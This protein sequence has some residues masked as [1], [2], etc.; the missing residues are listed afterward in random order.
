M[1]GPH[2]ETVV[3]VPPGRVGI[4]LEDFISDVSNTIIASVSGS[5]P[6]AGKVFQGDSIISVNGVDVRKMDTSNILKVFERYSEEYKIIAII[7]RSSNRQEDAALATEL[8]SEPMQ[9]KEQIVAIPPGRIGIHLADFVSNVSSTVV[10]SVSP[11]S[12]LVGK[13]FEGDSIT[14]VNGVD[15]RKM[16]TLGLFDVFQ[17]YSEE[18]KVITIVRRSL[19]YD[20]E[21]G[22]VSGKALSIESEPTQS[23][24]SST[25]QDSQHSRHKYQHDSPHTSATSLVQKP[26]KS[27]R[28]RHHKKKEDANPSASKP[29]EPQ[30]KEYKIEIINDN[31]DDRSSSTKFQHSIERKERKSGYVVGLARTSEHD[32]ESPLPPNAFDTSLSDSS[33]FKQQKFPN[34]TGCPTEGI[35]SPTAPI[36][37]GF[38][39]DDSTSKKSTVRKFCGA[40]SCTQSSGRSVQDKNIGDIAPSTE[41]PLGTNLTEDEISTITMSTNHQESYPS[42]SNNWNEYLST[43]SQ[44]QAAPPDERQHS[45]D[46]SDSSKDIEQ[47]PVNDQYEIVAD[48]VV[49]NDP[50][51]YDAELMHEVEQPNEELCSPNIVINNMYTPADDELKVSRQGG[52]RRLLPMLIP[53]AILIGSGFIVLGIVLGVGGSTS[54]SAAVKNN[55]NKS[56]EVHQFMSDD[57]SQIS[58]VFQNM[59]TNHYIIVYKNGTQADVGLTRPYYLNE[60]MLTDGTT[61]TSSTVLMAQTYLSVT[62][63]SNLFDPESDMFVKET[64]TSTTPGGTTATSSLMTTPALTKTTK[65]PDTTTPFSMTTPDITTSIEIPDVASTSPEPVQVSGNDKCENAIALEDLPSYRAGTTLMATPDFTSELEPLCGTSLASK[66]VWYCF[67]SDKQTIIRLE[68]ELKIQ[69]L[70]ESVLSIYTGS[71]NVGSLI[72]NNMVIADYHWSENN[73]IA[74]YEF[75]PEV[76]ETYRFLLSGANGDTAGGYE[77]RVTELEIPS[78]DLCDNATKIAT[79]P[80]I[81]LI[82][83]GDTTGAT[84]DFNITSVGIHGCVGMDWY[85][86]GLWY[87]FTGKGTS[88]RLE[89]HMYS[90][91]LGNSELSIFTGSCGD[92]VCVQNVEGE[93]H[94]SDYNDMTAYEFFAVENQDYWFLLYGQDFMT[95]GTYEFKV[96]EYEVPSNDDCVKATEVTVSQSAPFTKKGLSTLGATP[97]FD[98]S[99]IL[100]CVVDWYTRGVWYR[101]I[102]HGTVLRMEYQLY[103]EGMGNS[104]LAIFRGLCQSLSCG[105]EDGI[106]GGWHYSGY[107]DLVVHEFLAEEGETYYVWLSGENFNAAAKYDFTVSEYGIPSNDKCENATAM[108]PG[109]LYSGT[110][111]GSTP[112]F[113]AFNQKCGGSKDN[114]G[115]WY[116][117][118]G[119]G[120]LTSFSYTPSYR[121]TQLSL[122]GGTCDNLKCEGN[123]G[124]ETSFSLAPAIGKQYRLFI[125]GYSFDAVG[126]YS[127]SMEQYDRPANDVCANAVEVTSFPYTVEGNM[128]GA[129]Q[130][131]NNETVLCGEDPLYSGLWYSFVGVG[132]AITLELKTAGTPSDFW[133]EIAVFQGQCGSF[134]CI[135]QDEGQ[136]ENAVVNVIFPSAAGAQYKVLI[137]T[138]G[139]PTYDVSFQ[140]SAAEENS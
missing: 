92:L 132:T 120:K 30:E 127:L 25:R 38:V 47:R 90:I 104:Q 100:T 20:E 14:S 101:I 112:D 91:G 54:N 15:V 22:L 18:E 21:A 44:Q 85:T 82:L 23:T 76:G 57:H 62:P 73:D 98:D 37:V 133:G 3:T 109:L 88:V 119:N 72:C 130:D 55:N 31:A 78:N 97:D 80:Q 28:R 117:F 64:T 125:S 106:A 43:T 105:V 116:S 11:S 41:V 16:D 42:G 5:S 67:K 86:R 51:I 68:Y 58:N 107:N 10:T 137:A 75:L 96:T 56:T 1:S 29:L 40:E 52:W 138:W 35:S 129:T 136:G 99:N 94:Y 102:G 74:I 7:H 87:Q 140:F 13:V 124:T 113:N 134:Q 81:P 27:K 39:F 63:S 128:K 65:S 135:I 61:T 123:Y 70:G 110:T 32:E 93:W 126:D 122:F 95:V 50:E 111:A 33:A 77:F 103:S 131:F 79:V 59:T 6:L 17:K 2:M 49:V 71:C 48:A 115:V 108:S 60:S 118:T 84:P 66:G 121:D 36:P 45:F 89:Y 34:I 26:S 114:R 24:K 8:D 139:L 53:T 83:K 46:S 12:P 69:G 4:Q 9:W 19:T